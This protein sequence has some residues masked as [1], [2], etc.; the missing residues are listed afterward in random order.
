M[1]SICIWNFVPLILPN[2][3]SKHTFIACHLKKMKTLAS[4]HA[5]CVLFTTISGSQKTTLLK[6]VYGNSC[7]GIK[8]VDRCV[9]SILAS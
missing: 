4:I 7:M 5:T 1:S 6:K 3:V 9:Y 8:G 2:L